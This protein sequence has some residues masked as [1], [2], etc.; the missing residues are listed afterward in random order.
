MA[1]TCAGDQSQARG[2]GK[3][4]L[5]EPVS[6][7]VMVPSGGDWREPQRLDFLAPSCERLLRRGGKRRRG[8]P[9]GLGLAFPDGSYESLW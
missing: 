8:H 1:G 5:K 2:H 3:W 6:T 4:S 7:P 9:R